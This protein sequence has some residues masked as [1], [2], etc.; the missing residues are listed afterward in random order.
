MH[1]ADEPLIRSG[2]LDLPPVDPCPNIHPLQDG[3]ILDL[4]D[5]SLEVINI[6]GH[7]DGSILLL[8]H[9]SR[10]LFSG[11]TC[12]RR[13]LYG[14]WSSVSLND[15]CNSLRRLYERD[16]DVIYSAHDRCALPKAY[17]LH[18]IDMIRNE[19][20]HTTKSWFHPAIGETAYLGQ[21]NEYT[22]KYFDMV[23]PR[24]YL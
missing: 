10:V 13:L 6:P 15:F 7:T 19:L 23:A 4:G 21:G 12:A 5:R 17:I 9:R 3:D 16:F 18:M 24:K 11:D 22:L 14:V 8:D 20:P 1:P 2:M